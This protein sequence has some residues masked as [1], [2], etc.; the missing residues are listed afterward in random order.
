M[1]TTRTIGARKAAARA[2]ALVRSQPP[3]ASDGQQGLTR[4][5]KAVS[6]KL[7]VYRHG[8]IQ[9]VDKNITELA[10]QVEVTNRKNI[11]D[12]VFISANGGKVVNRY[13]LIDN[14]LYRVLYEAE[15]QPNG[16]IALQED[17]GGGRQYPNKLNVDQHNM[18]DSTGEAYW[19]F[20]N[21]FG[22]DSYD[23]AGAHMVTVN[24]DPRIEC[25]NA[26]WNGVDDQL[27][28]RGLLRRRRGPRVGSRLH[29]VH[30]GPDLPVAARRDERGLLRRLGR[31]RRPHQRPPGRG[32]GR[33][34][35]RASRR[36]L[37]DAHRRAA[38]AVDQRPVDDRQGL[39]RP[40]ARR[41]ASR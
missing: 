18:V 22:R 23:A 39:P 30:V 13:S 16:T 29:R 25:P 9:G 8:L 17:L 34:R 3:G 21:A 2:V 41:S 36:A 33:H 40:E 7:V 1:D 26:N 27:L 35:R 19:L 31:D 37:L 20:N 5:L 11:R 4:G 10:Y 24:N 6:T 12:V 15:L 14:A 32:R 28:R 38:A